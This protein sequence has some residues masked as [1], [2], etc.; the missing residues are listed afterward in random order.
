MKSKYFKKVRK[1]A[2]WWIVEKWPERFDYL[3]NYKTENVLAY[4]AKQAATRYMK[5]Y[6]IEF[7]TW[8]NTTI[9]S[10]HSFAKVAVKPI[11]HPY[12]RFRTFWR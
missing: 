2:K 1:N 9:E 7:S 8:N 4:T 3:Y 5:R 10:S 11:D 6:G 12:P